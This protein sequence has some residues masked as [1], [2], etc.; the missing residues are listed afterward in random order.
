[1]IISWVQLVFY[2]YGML[3]KVSFES[4]PTLSVIFFY[5]DFT[6]QLMSFLSDYFINSKKRPML[7]ISAL[8]SCHSGNLS[9]INLCDTEF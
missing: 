2:V 9:R 5:T 1:M 4:K 6:T 8:L 7:D 3:H